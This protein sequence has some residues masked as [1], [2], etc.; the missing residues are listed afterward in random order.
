MKK[1][2]I[3]SLILSVLVC[4]AF[5]SFGQERTGT[6][7][8]TVKDPNGAVVPNAAVVVS[9]NAFNRTVTANEDGFFRLQQVPPGTYTVVISAGSFDKITR[10]N[11]LV[12]LGNATVL[13]TEL[14]ASVGAVVNVTAEGIATIDSTSSKIQT[15]LG[16]KALETLPKGTNFTS[17]LKAAAPVRLEPTAGGFQI[18]GASGSENSFVLDGQEVTNFRDGTLNTNNNVPYQLIQEVQIKSNGFEAEFG[19]A[20]GGVINVVSK[21]GSDDFHGEVQQQLETSKLFARP[22][23]ILSTSTSAAPTAANRYIQPARDS[24]INMF[25]SFYVGGPVVKEHLYFFASATPQFFDTTRSYTFGDKVTNEYK[26]RTRRD[27]EFVRL[28]GQVTDKLQV[29]ATYLYNPI[30][31]HGSLPTFTT[32]DAA[33]SSSTAAPTVYDQQQIGG[34]IPA[35]NYTVEGIYTPTQWLTLNARYGKGYLNEKGTSYGIPQVT[36]FTC[37]SFACNV[38]GATQQAGYRNVAT[39][40]GTLRDISTRKSFDL[41]A[42]VYVNDFGGRHNFKF[43][44]QYTK[45]ANDVSTGNLAFGSIDF[46][47]DPTGTVSDSSGNLRGPGVAADFAAGVRGIGTLQFFGTGGNVGSNN[48]AL[49]VQDS[50]QI[51]KRLTI[52]AGIRAEKEDVPSFKEGAPGI[53]FGWKDKLAPRIGAAFDILGDGKWKVFGSYG[54]FFDRFKYE[55]P[56]G[57]FGGD[58]YTQYEFLLKNTDINT[59]GVAFATTNAINFTDF[60]LPSNDPS[61]NRIDPNLKPFQQAELTFGTAYDF[62]QGFILEGRYTRKHIVRAIDDIGYH[63]LNDDEEYFIGNPGEGVCTQP[64]CGKYSIPGA[65][66]ARAKRVYNGVEVRIQKR[67]GTNITMDGSYTWSRLFGNYSGSASSDEAQRGGGIGR[68]SPAVSRY[69]DLP[70]LGYTADGKPDDGLLPTDRTHF[71]KFAGNYRFD[72]WGNKAN[73]TDFNIFYQASSGTPVTTRT[74]IAFVSGQIVSARGD[75]GRLNMFSQTD[76]GLTHKYRFGAD[77]RY[78]VAFDINVLNLWN[79]AGELSRRETITRLNV[80]ESTFGCPTPTSDTPLRC[81]DRGFF[82]GSVTAAKILAYANANSGANLD[83]RY[84]LAQLYQDPRGVRFGFRFIF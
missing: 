10:N 24:F 58:I 1:L 61:D 52:N 16:A 59:Y 2:R 28:D 81:I 47:F 14:K 5:N 40:S 30:S 27:Y 67:F 70:F 39:N 76:I 63:N 25:P 51:G 72:W 50:W 19:G 38:G 77:S 46:N 78:A 37:A 33:K 20:T 6:I 48:H 41:G 29:N 22:R 34:R 64:A 84:N 45:L 18:D 35:T 36:Q 65:V 66:A 73:T 53:E 42:G 83:T 11:V 57:S 56:R 60:R 71:F 12:T 4:L 9:G 74:R 3:L 15:N 32:L 49:F 23:Q 79:Q 54:R 21:R 31:I 80:P 43:G 62:G 17:S 82:N 68:N 26:S 55:L 44:Y 13:D 7:E 75:L 69:F 8:G